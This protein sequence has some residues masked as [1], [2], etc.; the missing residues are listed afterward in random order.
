M[1]DVAP[2]AGPSEASARHGLAVNGTAD[3]SRSPADRPR[4]AVPPPPD[5]EPCRYPAKAG[6]ARCTLHTEYPGRRVDVTRWADQPDRLRGVN[7]F[8]VVL[9]EFSI[10]ETAHPW[11]LL[12]PILAENGG[13]AAFLYTPAGRN[14]G[15]ELYEQARQR[16]DWFT[17]LKTAEDTRRW[18][19]EEGGPIISRAQ[20]EEEIAAGMPRAL[21]R[22]SGAPSCPPPRGRTSRRSLRAPS[23]R[24]GSG[25]CRGI[26]PLGVT[27]AW[28]LGISDAMA[29]VF[30]QMI[31]IEVQII[32]YLEDTGQGLAYYAKRLGENPIATR[33]TSCRTTP[34][35]GRNR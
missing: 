35:S 14:H 11:D 17:T 32:D 8:G 34:T 3:P 25:T 6:T 7:P 33:N 23:A 2:E 30:A 27:T 21:A 29:I 24:A 5:R 28:D 1:S 4:C 15:Q 31:G 18:A 20:I 16:A 22:S 10:M 26:P 13:W 19:G 12:R 9:D